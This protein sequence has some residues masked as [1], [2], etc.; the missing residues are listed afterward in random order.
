MEKLNGRCL[1]LK[2]REQPFAVSIGQFIGRVV[3]TLWYIAQLANPRRNMTRIEL[4]AILKSLNLAGN[5]MTCEVAFMVQDFMDV[6]LIRPSIMMEASMIR[7]ACKALKDFDWMHSALSRK[8]MTVL[9]SRQRF[10]ALFLLGGT[11]L[12]FVII[13]TM[14]AGWKA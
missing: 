9:V 2:A 11:V 7:A 13:Y 1:D 5:S 12:P 8:G 3:P 6:S 10:P 4:S 14:L